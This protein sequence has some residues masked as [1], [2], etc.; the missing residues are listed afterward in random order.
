MAKKIKKDILFSGLLSGPKN[1]ASI[2]ISNGRS[3]IWNKSKDSIPSEISAANEENKILEPDGVKDVS[4]EVSIPAS[5]DRPRE[6]TLARFNKI[7][8]NA[9]KK[10]NYLGGSLNS[11]YNRLAKSSTQ[12]KESTSNKIDNLGNSLS[13]TYSDLTKSTGEYYQAGNAQLSEFGSLAKKQ[14]T[15]AG[16]AMVE[17]KTGISNRYEALEIKDGLLKLVSNIDTQAVVLALDQINVKDTKTKL[18]IST[19]KQILIRLDKH[20]T[21]AVGA[22]SDAVSNQLNQDMFMLTNSINL[23]NALAIAEPFVHLIPYGGTALYIIGLF[24]KD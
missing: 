21:L 18:A 2:L 12:L 9:S 6:E 13:N 23:K 11:G 3:R 16:D 19:I 4:E 14:L 7:K 20:N 1:S 22:H 24:V 10:M 15:D 8:Q 17:F 5:Y